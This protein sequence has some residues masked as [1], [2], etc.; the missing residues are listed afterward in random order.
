MNFLSAFLRRLRGKVTGLNAIQSSFDNLQSKLNEI[1]VPMT[2][3]SKSVEAM[4]TKHYIGR[5]RVADA[6]PVVTQLQSNE[7]IRIVFIVQHPSVWSSWRSVWVA[8]TKGQRFI[9]KV[10]LTPF[11][12]PIS[13]AAVT[14]DD[15]KK[16]LIDEKVPFCTAEFFDVNSFKPHVTF[17]QNPYEYTRPANIRID[18]LKKAGSRIAYIPYGLEIGGGAWNI[19]AQFDSPVHRSAWRIFARSERHKAMFGKYCHVGND[20][21]FV[22]GHPKFDTMNVRHCSC[23]PVGLTKKIADRKVLL[24]TPHFSVG[25]PPTWS[26]YNLYGDFI[27][28]EMH[29][30]QDLFMLI[31]PHPMFFQAMQQN[32]VWGPDGETCFR[33]MVYESDNLWLDVNPDYHD[34]FSVSDA[35]ITDVGSFLLE[36]LPTGKPILYLHHPN[37]LGMNDD[38]DLVQYLYSASGPIEIEAFMKMFALGDDH[39]KKEREGALSKFLHG[40]D[41]NIGEHIC[42]HIYSS[43]STGDSWSPDVSKKGTTV[44]AGSEKYWHKSSCT[45]LAPSDY[46]DRK[47]VVLGDLLTKRS[48]FNKAIDIGCRDGRFTRL[49]AKYADE[50]TGYDISPILVNKAKEASSN[51]N[52]DNTQ[53][54]CQEIEKIAPAE[55]FDLVSCMGV[56]SCIIEDTKFLHILDKFSLLSM[57]GGHLLLI[58]TLSQI[59]EQIVSDQSGYIAKYRKMGDYLNLIERRGFRLIENLLITENIEKKLINKLFFFKYDDFYPPQKTDTT[60]QSCQ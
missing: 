25:E 5:E 48:S 43:I 7:A 22:V 42:Q 6:L 57:Q 37:G 33:K 19:A 36:Y 13:S 39:R 58:D 8:A 32:K 53:F 10:V 50:V 56:T 59:Q 28:S 44:Q 3:C 2:S 11:I 54:V 60:S 18:Q 14:Y 29:R 35:L 24:W 15:M 51:D 40:L 4:Y 1:A 47:E 26:T 16:C 41:S 23:M 31:R 12:H 49:L 21:V 38:R 30:R 27:L 45:Y 34:A 46:Y 20:H 52:I 17:V 55:K 9:S